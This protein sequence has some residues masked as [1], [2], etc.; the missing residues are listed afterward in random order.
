MVLKKLDA[1]VP[2]KAKHESIPCS[3]SSADFDITCLKRFML[4][5]PQRP[6]SD[7]TTIKHAFFE[8]LS[9]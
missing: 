7:D 1:F 2:I 4:R 3:F 6:L 9:S 5:P 8:A